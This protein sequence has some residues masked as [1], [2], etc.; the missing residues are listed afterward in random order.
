M[1]IFEIVFMPILIGVLVIDFLWIATLVFKEII[2]YLVSL[3]N[4]EHHITESVTDEKGFVVCCWEEKSNNASD[5]NKYYTCILV[6]EHI[7]ISEGKYNYDIFKDNEGCQ[8]EFTLHTFHYYN[9][10]EYKLEF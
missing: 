10:N 1:T 2:S 7:I 3:E 9:H 5:D 6:D 4:E 8:I